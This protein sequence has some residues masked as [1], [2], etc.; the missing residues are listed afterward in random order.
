MYTMPT[1]H[2]TGLR[3]LAAVAGVMA[4]LLLR[5]SPTLAATPLDFLD[6]SPDITAGLGGLSV[7]DEDVAEDDLGGGLG[8]APLGALPSAADLAAY[9]V[10]ANGEQLLAFDTTVSLPGGL[11]AEPRDV[12]RYNGAT[13]SLEFNG[14]ANG[15]PNGTQVDA[16]SV[17]NG[18]DLLLSFDTTVVLSGLSVDDEDLVRFDGSTFS[19]F[20]DGSVEGVSTA[21]DLDAAHHIDA[22][23]HLLL[24]FDG[25]GTVGGVDFDDEDVLE[26]DPVAGTW[27]LAYDGSAQHSGWLTADLDAVHAL[28]P[29][30]FADGFESGDTSAWSSTVP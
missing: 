15:V 6:A 1:H 13:Y 16:V 30:I 2:R 20:F 10:L 21:L 29:L 25:S 18:G 17:L 22:N 26:Y 3:F 27:L 8:L 4:L 7:N 19:L 14:A 24:S 11:T 23:G 12:V 9:H 5:L 28:S